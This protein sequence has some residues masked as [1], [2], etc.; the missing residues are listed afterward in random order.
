MSDRP[1]TGLHQPAGGVPLTSRPDWTFFA[2]FG[3]LGTSVAPVGDVNGDGFGDII[4]GVPGQN[5]SYVFFGSTTGLSPTPSVE[6]LG[7]Q[8]GADFG[9]SVSSAGDVNGDGFADFIMAAPLY[10]DDFLDEGR[11]YVYM[12]RAAGL[13][14]TPFW[15]L[16]GGQPGAQFGYAV[17][18]AG[19]V[20]GDGLDDV[21]VSAPFADSGQ[22]DEGRV[23][24]YLG[25][26]AGLSL[27]P[28]WA[29][30]L[31][32]DGAWF[33]SSV[34]AAGDVNGDGYSDV[35][36]GAVRYDSGETDQGAAFVYTGSPQGLSGRPVWVGVGEQPGAAF[37]Q[38][39]GTAG[40]VN[41]DG[42]SD[43]IVGA[44]D[45]GSHS[46]LPDGRA[47][48]Y[49]GSASGVE[50]E[51]YWQAT[52]G[53]G[54]R[55]G[56][57]VATT[58][59]VNDDGLSDI[60]VGAKPAPQ[61]GVAKSFAFVFFSSDSGFASTPDWAASTEAN[62]VSP[63]V[64]TAGDVNGDGLS[65]VL[66]G[67]A[68][69]GTTNPDGRVSVYH[70]VPFLGTLG[71]EPHGLVQEG[72]RDAWFGNSVASAGDVNGDGWT[73][74]IVGAYLQDGTA[75]DA[76]AAFLYLGSPSGLIVEPWW[77]GWGAGTAE[78]FG[79]SVSSAGDINGDGFSDVIV[80][81]P[82]YSNGQGDEGGVFVYLGA[83]SGL[84]RSADWIGEGDQAGAQ[85]GF[86][87]ARAGDVN[88]D[89]YSD[90]IV[91]AYRYSGG[92]EEEG[93]AVVLYG[94]PYGLPDSLSWTAES[95]QAGA[96]LGYSVAGAG[97]VNGDGYSDVIVGA[98]YF[99]NGEEDEGRAMIYAGS[100]G[101]L[102]AEPMW[103]AEIDH[104]V[105][106]FGVSV[107][108]AGDIN[109]DGYGDVVIGAEGNLDVL[110]DIGT[111]FVYL[112][113]P[114]GPGSSPDWAAQGDVLEG[115]FGRAV[116]SAGDINGDGFGDLA[117]GDP[118]FDDGEANEGRVVVYMG[119]ANGLPRFPDW[120]AEGNQSGAWLGFSVAAAGD[121]NGDGLADIVV[122]A[123]RWLAG[124]N[125]SGIA[126]T[127]A[128]PGRAP[129]LN[130]RQIRTDGSAS[131]GLLGYS[132]DA[133]SIRLKV[134]TRPPPGTRTILMEWE[135]KPYG[136]PFDGTNTGTSARYPLSAL[137]RTSNDAVALAELIHVA[138]APENVHWR[139]RL[140]FGSPIWPRTRWLTQP[141]NSTAEADLRMGL[142]PHIAPPPP[143]PPKKPP[144]FV[145]GLE[146]NFPNPFNPQTTIRYTLPE[147]GRVRV[148]VFD[149]RGQRVRVL[150][151]VEQN[152]GDYPLSWD[153]RDDHG[154]EVASGIYFLRLAFFGNVLA[155]KMVL[156]R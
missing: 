151:D 52:V 2:Q 101:G 150:L 1:V 31:D 132:G 99:D 17:S 114:S 122:G 79:Y 22:Q 71:P 106:R 117:I 144:S 49:L 60:I 128:T 47:Y 55:F 153:G 130:P 118:H 100:A 33:G 134:S 108:S 121:L 125:R 107:A 28:A 149:V 48:V 83:R 94:S 156:I 11:V 74:M 89:G 62:H 133:D 96:W 129:F 127:Y 78:W 146:R 111:V 84:G 21:L 148:T 13:M 86:S 140:D 70:A 9:F 135:A 73:D 35:I 8:S 152:E 88:G 136:V 131:V 120:S 103:T 72:Q 115:A 42:F 61:F 69:D 141:N 104:A 67:N 90:V 14:D 119:S 66:V 29:M 5:R 19:D 25:E 123:P 23:Y 38:A 40:D 77:R 75:K 102:L 15:K 82:R 26:P 57:A 24:L 154:R 137:D 116:S 12:G 16:S 7:S 34:A 126:L 32:Q 56:F 98:P 41:G 27:I 58:G 147:R 20:N 124:S 68:L 87:V 50:T 18:W 10:D 30:E 145:L 97:D 95:H 142:P 53:S 44:S 64:A 4:V 76:G 3:R 155:Q 112:G 39:V 113:S 110:Q 36:I 81:A 93:R 85:Y 92:E 6:L 54:T 91:G 80:G 65:D 46:G 59:D 105:G 51:P 37:A 143:P 109:G 43:I 45:Y 139:V 63:A 138:G